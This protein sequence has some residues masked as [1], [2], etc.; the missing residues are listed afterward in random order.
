MIVDT[1]VHLLPERLAA[2]I[3]AFF[4]QHMPDAML[5][6]WQLAPARASIQAAGVERCWSLPYAHKPGMASALNRWMAE[7]F[8]GDP[9]VEPGGT[10]HPGDDVAAVVGE[11]L[12]D[13]G[14]RLMKLHCSV[15]KFA[16]DDPRLD[17]LWK[18][19]SEMGWPVVVHA[20]H[21]IDGRTDAAEIAPIGRVATRWPEARIIVAHCGAPAVTATIALMHEHRSLYAD[22]TPVIDD[23]TPVDSRVLHGLAHRLLFGSDAPNTG[24]RIEDAI[25][26]V[27]GFGLSE[28]HTDAILGGN[29]RTLL[30]R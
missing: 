18:R 27:R 24:V 3:R 2:A 13:L 20:G 11:A 19:V 10:V 7:T 14:L 5:Y 25:A 12:D 6:P 21:A 8:G 26:H 9:L 1:H 17:P 30:D 15:G 16:P 29:A 4:E 22:L 23:V 28:A